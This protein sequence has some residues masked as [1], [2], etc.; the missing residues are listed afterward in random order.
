[1]SLPGVSETQLS[2]SS[3]ACLEMKNL[4]KKFEV[5]FMKI[6]HFSQKRGFESMSLWSHPLD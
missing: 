2:C 3:D 1:M 6:V 5:C 4:E